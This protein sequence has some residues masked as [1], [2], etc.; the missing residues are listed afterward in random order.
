MVWYDA[1]TVVDGATD[2][3][4]TFDTYETYERWAE[5]LVAEYLAANVH[6]AIYAIAHTCEA[7]EPGLT[8]CGCPQMVT[9]CLPDYEVSDGDDRDGRDGRDDRDGRVDRLYRARRARLAHPDGRFDRA[10]RWYP[11]E[12]EWRACCARIRPPSRRWPYSLLLHCRTR[13]HVWHLVN[14]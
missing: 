3:E 6:A 5:A 7:C 8:E 13:R 9:S 14:T 12:S 4:G 10:G 1:W 2:Q 11:A